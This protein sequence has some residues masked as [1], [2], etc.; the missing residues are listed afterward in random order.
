MDR[1]DFI[2]L[3]AVVP[4][5]LL[6]FDVDN[7]LGKVGGGSK[8]LNLAPVENTE[9]LGSSD[10]RFLWLLRGDEHFKEVYYVN[11]RYSLD[12]YKRFCW[13]MRDMHEGQDGF[14]AI[15]ASL[16]N[17]LYKIQNML[18]SHGMR[19]PMNVNSGYRSPRTNAMTEGSAKNS[20]HMKGKAIDITIAGADATLLGVMGMMMQKGGVGFY[21]NK[22]FIHLD[23]GNI[24]TWTIGSDGAMRGA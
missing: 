20:Y 8:P 3:G 5:A 24:R 10:E 7:F 19:E 9:V 23:T 21:P 2:K 12:S 6:A 4:S 16:M 22:N 13:I 18:V 14:V 1:R 17:L 15:D 11:G